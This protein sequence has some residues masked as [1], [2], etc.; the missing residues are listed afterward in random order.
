MAGN[1]KD[2]RIVTFSKDHGRY[3]AGKHAMHKTLAEK[4]KEA[5][6]PVKI[7]EAEPIVAKLKEKKRAQ[8]EKDNQE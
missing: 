8:I 4:L 6:A 5:K 2:V 1:I 7:E 3:K